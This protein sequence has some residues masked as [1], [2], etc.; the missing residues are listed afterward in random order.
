MTRPA[1][2]PTTNFG[3]YLRYL[4][5]RARL[6]QTELSIAVG[7]S[8]GQISMLENGQRLPDVT[9]V[10]ALFIVALGLERDQRA[11]TQLLQLAQSATN[12]RKDKAQGEEAPPQSTQSA[13]AG[14]PLIAQQLIWQREELGLLEE[15]PPL[16]QAYVGRAQAQGRVSQWLQRERRVAIC[17]LAGMGKS[18]LAA[19]IAHEY[20]RAH[21]VC[22]L[23][24]SPLSPLSPDG[25][26]HQLALFG[27]AHAADPAPLVRLLRNRPQNQLADQQEADEPP[28]PRKL[29][30]QLL[31]LVSSTL[32]TLDAPLLVFDDAHLIADDEALLGL[33]QRLFTLAPYCRA[34]FVTRT[35]ISALP[36]PHLT[37]D[38]LTTDET[39]SLVQSLL[40]PQNQL[41]GPRPLV[42][43][44]HQQTAG[45]P[46]LL[47]LALTQLEQQSSGQRHI[48]MLAQSLVDG[49]LR[50]LP[51]AARLLLDFLTIWRAPL[52]L[53]AAALPE[54]LAEF[55]HTYQQQSAVSTLARRRLIEHPHHATPHP[56][57]REALQHALDGQ[58][59]RRRA[60]HRLAAEWAVSQ[61]DLLEGAYHYCGAADL[62]SA[63]DLLAARSDD[64]TNRGQAVA[65][66]A[67]V[68]EVLTLARKGSSQDEARQAIVR[69]ML[70]LRGDLLLNTLQATIAQASYREAL[71][72][73]QGRVARAQLAERLATS[74]YQ[75]GQAQDALILCEQALNS[76]TLVLSAEGMRLRLQLGGTRVRALIALARFDEAHQLSQQA[77]DLARVLRLLKPSAADPI[78]IHALL[79]LG[80]IARIRG[81]HPDA[82]RYLEQAV[83]HARQSGQRAAEAEALTY[84]S[85]ARRDVGDFAGAEAAGGLSLQVAQA[86]G[87]DYLGSNALHYLSINDYY[88]NDLS[89]A[90]AR[91]DVA[92][93]QKRQMV[94]GEGVVSCALIQALIYAALGDPERS[95]QLV[96]RAQLE[97]QL[98][99]NRWL[100]GL[101]HYVSGIVA[102]FQLELAQAEQFFEQTLAND[103]FC[104]DRQ[105]HESVQ[106]FLG[107]VYV[108][109]ERVTEAEAIATRLVAPLAGMEIELLHGLL[110]GMIA[111]VHEEWAQAKA[112]AQAT[113]AH[114]QRTGYLVYAD[115]ARRLH[116][117]ATTPCPPAYLPRAVCCGLRA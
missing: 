83:H 20:E 109:Q 67:V 64:F 55:D 86:I 97:A 70:L 23:T 59:E 112:I 42:A 61:A 3:T 82:H 29:T 21:P 24:F 14:Q 36:M 80:Y 87:N 25:L 99:D 13:R 108:A 35:E 81:H 6:T 43:G 51:Q 44:L 62:Q 92:L 41:A 26:L 76:L 8:P 17:G 94:D 40:E 79:A 115:E 98:F 9:T 5:R 45:N 84:L 105:L 50:E 103:G 11:S 88:H 22:W 101:T 54:M 28:D 39:A 10:A 18:T 91:S 117:L 58:A 7:Y 96:T 38:G 111:L 48:P 114:A 52:D 106:I 75:T 66:A 47:R 34:L 72:L 63:C 85:A 2:E 110:R 37:L 89:K 53:S 71:E 12:E 68:E 31:F 46:L 4:R 19:T 107:I 15:I 90:L 104:N 102:A 93:A 77:V 27:A 30:R 56:L 16:P 1:L 73:T 69:Q 78:R 33:L 65:A 113:I 74:L 100:T 32:A 57:L 95:A 49:V 116:E 60:L